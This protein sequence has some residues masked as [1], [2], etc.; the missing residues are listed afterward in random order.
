MVLA[1]ASK[2]RERDKSYQWSFWRA[3]WKKGKM[4]KMRQ[5]PEGLESQAKETSVTKWML[6][7]LLNGQC[8]IVNW[9]LWF[10]PKWHG[11]SVTNYLFDVALESRSIWRTHCPAPSL[12]SLPLSWTTVFSYFIL[13]YLILF[14][15]YYFIFY[16]STK[17]TLIRSPNK[18]VSKSLK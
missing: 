3:V 10:T 11:T 8:S 5:L 14:H 1:S 9:L 12:E 15:F 2:S 6:V 4:Y 13:F 18:V 16:F 17:E 7:I